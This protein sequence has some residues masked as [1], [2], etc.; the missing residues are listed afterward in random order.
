MI[1]FDL[2]SVLLR[3]LNFIMERAW[4]EYA[5]VLIALVLPK[6][7]Q[8]SGI[9]IR[10]T[11]LVATTVIVLLVKELVTRVATK[12][13]QTIQDTDELPGIGIALPSTLKLK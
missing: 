6:L 13:G 12:N 4:I 2:V 9:A 8:D 7:G 11:Y 5:T 10:T 3:A 1:L